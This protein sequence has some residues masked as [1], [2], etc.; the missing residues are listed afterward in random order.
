MIVVHFDVVSQPHE[1]VMQRQPSPEGR[2]LWNVFFDVFYGRMIMLVDSDIDEQQ[3]ANWLR[4]E[5]FKPSLVYAAKDFALDGS[6]PCADAVW[7]I[8]AELG[9]VDWYLDA[10]PET[11]ALTLS[12]GIPTLLVAVPHVSRPEWAAPR[13]IRGWD[14]LSEELDRQALMRADRTWGDVE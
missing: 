6:T 7:N 12:K 11:C 5:R 3:A 9:K 2:R 8:S 4:R 13:Q 10:N 1:E 14:T